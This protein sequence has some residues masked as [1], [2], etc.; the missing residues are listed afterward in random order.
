[1]QSFIKMQK[2]QNMN[3]TSAVDLYDD[4]EGMRSWGSGKGWFDMDG[5]W[6]ERWTNVRGS[7]RNQGHHKGVLIVAILV[8]ERGFWFEKWVRF[9]TSF[10]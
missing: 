3:A 1:M 9:F 8:Q 7:K 5:G 4:D 10:L 6:L 2:P